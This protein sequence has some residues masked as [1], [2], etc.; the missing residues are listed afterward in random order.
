[1]FQILQSFKN[2][3]PRVNI[4]EDRE[5]I[6]QM[7]IS[8]SEI[9][10]IKNGNRRPRYRLSDSFELEDL[11]EFLDL[12]AVQSEIIPYE[13]W[14]PKIL[15]NV[16]KSVYMRP[17]YNMKEFDIFFLTNPNNPS[18]YVERRSN[19]VEGYGHFIDRYDEGPDREMYKTYAQGKIALV[20]LKVQPKS[21]S[22]QI[23]YL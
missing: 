2:I 18:E 21:L 19:Y 4:I 13:N 16:I 9:L 1:M 20:F 10:D 11:L 7:M 15:A 23:W 12:P 5:E 17:P 3:F 6:I 22:E 8:E 14:H